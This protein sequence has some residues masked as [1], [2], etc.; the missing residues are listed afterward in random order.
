[1]GYELVDVQASNGGRHLRLFIDK[2]GGVT[3]DPIVVVSTDAPAV[4]TTRTVVGGTVTT[5][6]VEALPV[7]SRSPLDLIFTLPGVSRASP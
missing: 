1:M 6:E 2:P 3:V 5:E 4:D 7:N